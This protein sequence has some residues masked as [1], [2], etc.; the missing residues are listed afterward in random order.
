MKTS[1]RGVGH[2]GF[3]LIELLV[4]VSI[5]G[6]LIGLLLPAVQSARAMGRRTQCQS[7]LR[8]V[9]IGILGYANTYGKFPPAGV[10]SDDPKKQN[11]GTPPIDVPRNQGIVSWHDPKCTPDSLE[12]PMYNWVVEILPYIDQQDLANAWAKTGPDSSGSTVPQSYLSTTFMQPGQPC[13]YLISS[14]SLTVLRC[15]EDNTTD[16]GEGNLS[17]VVNGGFSLWTALPLGWT[18]SATDGQPTA[19]AYD[20]S[21]MRWAPPAQGWGGNLNVCRKTGVMF[22]EDYGPYGPSPTQMPWNA[23]TTFAALYDGA[24][25]TLL[26]SENTLAGAGPASPYSKNAETNWASPLATFCMFFGPPIVCGADGQCISGPLQPQSGG[27]D[28]PGWAMANRVGTFANINFGQNLTIEGS[29]PFSNSGHVGGC[30]MAFCDGSVRF[31]SAT[32][33]GTVYAKLITPAGARLPNYARQFPL[34]QDDF[35]P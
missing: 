32:I 17:Y 7:N 19:T 23:R 21:G 25:S 4:V 1:G 31:I 20:D 30:N 15:P 11:P 28:G 33:D 18:G 14:T 27:V 24:S 5:V 26:L 3:T 16:P 12:V 8:N 9:A 34:S 22:L 13:N 2:R 35:V 6:L 10:I 29:F